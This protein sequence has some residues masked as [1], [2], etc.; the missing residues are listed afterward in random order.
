MKRIIKALLLTISIFIL[1][2]FSGVDMQAQNNNAGLEGTWVLDS[3]QVAETMP[4]SIVQKTVLL[5]DESKFSQGWMQQFTIDGKG[6]MSY[7]TRDGRNIP[8]VPYHINGGQENTLTLMIVQGLAHRAIKIQPLS[9][10]TI[11]ITQAFRT[12]YES[13]DIEISWRMYYHKSNK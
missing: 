10:S 7:T 1:F 12:K 13:D 5:G 3:V 8:N 2:A 4:G 6:K 9:E 11:L